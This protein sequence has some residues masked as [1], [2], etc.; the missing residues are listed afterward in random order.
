LAGTDGVGGIG[1]DDGEYFGADKG[2]ILSKSGCYR[3]VAA[4]D[5]RGTRFR[6]NQANIISWA[7]FSEGK[8][9]AGSD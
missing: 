2:S 3:I 1:L 6:R 8:K 4:A 7:N 5:G 9:D